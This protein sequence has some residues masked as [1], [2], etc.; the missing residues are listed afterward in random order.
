MVTDG[1]QT[2]CDVHLIRYI[3]VESPCCTLETDII[4]Y[5]IHNFKKD[6]GGFI[7]DVIADMDFLR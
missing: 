4:L 7:G 3:D 2:Y 6:K 1:Y 5:V